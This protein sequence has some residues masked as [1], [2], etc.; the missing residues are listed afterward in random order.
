MNLKIKVDAW[1]KALRKDHAC[2][3]YDS[4]RLEM[5]LKSLLSDI[6]DEIERRCNE[7]TD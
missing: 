5:R 2:S 3:V 1:I 6:F 7:E 4:E